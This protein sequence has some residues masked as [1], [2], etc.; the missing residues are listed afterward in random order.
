MDGASGSVLRMIC[1]NDG[2]MGDFR[3]GPLTGPLVPSQT[4]CFVG[5]TSAFKGARPP[6]PPRNSTTG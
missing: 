5:A 3:G 1:C 6:R 4:R 2:L